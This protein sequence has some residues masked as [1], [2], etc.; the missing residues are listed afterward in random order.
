VFD[1]DLMIFIHGV[2]GGMKFSHRPFKGIFN[3]LIIKLSYRPL[4]CR[5]KGAENRH[6]R[7]RERFPLVRWRKD[8]GT[9]LWLPA[10]FLS[11]QSD[12]EDK[13]NPLLDS[14]N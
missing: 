6:C 13:S 8:L 1:V 11:L 3:P 10:R 5:N 2:G 7:F 4:R 9:L 12:R 14:Y